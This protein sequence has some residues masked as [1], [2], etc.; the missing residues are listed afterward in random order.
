MA[1]SWRMNK[2]LCSGLGVLYRGTGVADPVFG[3]CP[4]RI[5]ALRGCVA[6]SGALYEME[7]LQ[8]E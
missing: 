8:E 6:D 4:A 2:I 3:E 1:L 5:G 7:D